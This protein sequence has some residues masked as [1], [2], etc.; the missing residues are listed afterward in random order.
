MYAESMPRFRRVPLSPSWIAVT[1]VCL[2]VGLALLVAGA[3]LADVLG[4]SAEPL[5]MGPFRWSMASG[6]V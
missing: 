5:L 1:V 2:L 6:V 4:H 3:V